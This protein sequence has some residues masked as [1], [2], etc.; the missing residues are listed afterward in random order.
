MLTS[1]GCSLLK[2]V[3]CSYLIQ[4][5]FTLLGS[6]FYFVFVVAASERPNYTEPNKRCQAVICKMLE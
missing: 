6:S 1:I 3:C 4:K 2:I 5:T